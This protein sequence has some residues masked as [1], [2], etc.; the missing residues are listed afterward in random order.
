MR[1]LTV[2]HLTKEYGDKTAVYDLTF[3]LGEGQVYGFLGA[4]GAGKTTT[5]R[6]LAGL[7]P[8]TEGEIT[9]CGHDLMTEGEEA[10][11]CIGYLPDVPP[12]YPDF[13]VGEMLRFAASI[14]GCD[15]AEAETSAKEAVEAFSLDG[16]EQ[17]IIRKLSRGYRQRVGFALASIGDP[18][19][20]LLDEPMTGLDPAQSLQVRSIIRAL[21]KTHTVL[22][23]TH[24]IAEAESL[25]DS[26]LVIADGCLKAFDTPDALLKQTGQPT[27][28]AAFLALSGGGGL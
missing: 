13:T 3:R 4:N 11:R 1:M 7:L 19:V 16:Y 6:M 27:L 22:L 20:L 15:A 14:R 21:G 8:P 9:I 5:F 25:C 24:H 28:E 23:S 17:K 18:K 10:R 26:I 2:R 12:L